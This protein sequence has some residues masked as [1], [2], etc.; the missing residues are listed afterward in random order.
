M[1][2][3]RFTHVSFLHVYHHSAMVFAGW[4]AIRFVP[5]GH[6]TMVGVLNCLVHAIMYGYYLISVVNENVKQSIWW[7]KY[8]T[9]I[10]MIQFMCLVAHF[11]QTL[12]DPQCGYPKLIATLMTTQNVCMLF[13]FADFYRNAYL[14][15]KRA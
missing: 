14:K 4:I 6:G 1:L 8:I 11:G 12:I 2:R 3:K 7:K 10:Q 15:K 13:M 5:A 9:Q